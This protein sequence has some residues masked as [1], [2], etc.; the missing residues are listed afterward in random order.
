MKTES[1]VI[2]EKGTGKAIFELFDSRIVARLD[3]AK[4]EAVPV[5]EFPQAQPLESAGQPQS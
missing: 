4:Y 3:T 5:H 1:W 2:R